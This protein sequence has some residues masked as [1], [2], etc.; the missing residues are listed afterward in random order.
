VQRCNASCMAE[1]MGN[2][3]HGHFDMLESSW[4]HLAL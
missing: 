1:P 3:I 4:R 2:G